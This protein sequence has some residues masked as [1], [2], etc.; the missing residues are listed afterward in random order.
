M[1]QEKETH[2]QSPPAAGR[3]FAPAYARLLAVLIM[4]PLLLIIG[5]WVLASE[6]SFGVM[7]EVA[8]AVG[9]GSLAAA[10]I[11]QTLDNRER[12]AVDEIN[13]LADRAPNIRVGLR[14]L[15]TTR[16]MPPPDKNN[17][18]GKPAVEPFEDRELYIENVGPGVAANLSARL[19]TLYVDLDPDDPVCETDFMMP[20]EL[21][22][23]PHLYRSSELSLESTYLAIGPQNQMRLFNLDESEEWSGT[24]YL[25]LDRVVVVQL[26]FTDLEGNQH[27]RI[28]GGAYWHPKIPGMNGGYPEI[29]LEGERNR[30]RWN[31][32]RGDLID[33]VLADWKTK[34]KSSWNRCE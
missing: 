27:R 11:F 25:A 6:P 28:N 31:A 9:T 19:V 22:K 2:R 26:Q 21:L 24:E 23:V 13:R 14:P 18:S 12:R 34:P 1:A 7:V 3:Y 29:E 10:A 4:V 30:S 16:R 20:K 17:P 5:V 32:A 8:V 33:E 15:Q